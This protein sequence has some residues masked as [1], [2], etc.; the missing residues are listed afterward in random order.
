M[1][2]SP[3][4]RPLRA[5]V[6]STLLCGALVATGGAAQARDRIPWPAPTPGEQEVLADGLLGPLSLAVGPH[7][8]AYV[9]QAFGGTIDAVRRGEVTPLLTADPGAEP[10]SLSA[11]GRRI[12]YTTSVAAATPDFDAH[13]LVRDA[14]GRT[15]HLA[16]IGAYERAANPDG[17]TQYGFG[18]LDQTCLDQLPELIPGSYTG[19][20]D[21]HPYATALWHGQVFVADAGSNAVFAVDRGGE[22]STLAVLPPAPLRV[23]AEVAEALG[24]PDCTVHH[25]Y[26][27]ESVPTD[28]EVGTDGWLYVTSLPGGPEGPGPFP[29]LG[30]V[31]KVDPK[32]GET[33]LV[34]RGLTG[35]TNLAIGTKGEIYVTELFANR[36]SVIPRGSTTPQPFLDLV[37]P[38][39][40]EFDGRSLYVTTEALPGE[41]APPSGKVVKVSLRR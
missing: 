13:L 18:D 32:T 22:V 39:A 33:Q 15:E 2:V 5:A 38:A 41:G 34:A 12:Y 10:G 26:L 23:T 11:E 6:T 7:D 40:V 4:S 9:S 8:T 25:D 30:A 31:F 3:L 19:G 17:G 1:H 27:L 36:V 20:V 24:L 16:D 37:L 28:V 21:S 14:Q 35:A 29:P